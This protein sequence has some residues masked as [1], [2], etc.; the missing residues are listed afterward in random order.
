MHLRCLKTGKGLFLL[1]VHFL[2][3]FV[4]QKEQERILGMEPRA[5]CIHARHMLC[6]AYMLGTCS[7]M[8]TC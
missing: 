4:E 2:L 5:L 8:H 6:Y 3:R 1:T 7:A